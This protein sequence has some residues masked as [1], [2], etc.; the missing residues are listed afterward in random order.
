M[1]TNSAVLMTSSSPLLSVPSSPP[2]KKTSQPYDSLICMWL[3]PLLLE[4]CLT[5]DGNSFIC[6][7]GCSLFD[8]DGFAGSSDIFLPLLTTGVTQGLWIFS[9]CISPKG[10]KH[11][12]DQL[13]IKLLLHTALVSKPTFILMHSNSGKKAF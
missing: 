12:S 4:E 8:R 11:P 2:P 3:L 13:Q 7:T 6:S 5:E 9:S 1:Q 10:K